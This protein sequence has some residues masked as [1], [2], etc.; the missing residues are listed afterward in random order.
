MILSSCLS[1]P[2]LCEVGY[3]EKV[4]ALVHSVN[5]WAEAAFEPALPQSPK[6]STLSRTIPLSRTQ[7]TGV[8]GDKCT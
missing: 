7:L 1:L 2:Q 4:L 8:L 5:F 3:T 6:F